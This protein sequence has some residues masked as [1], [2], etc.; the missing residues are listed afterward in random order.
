DRN[1]V[2]TFYREDIER[3]LEIR[4]QSVPRDSTKKAPMFVRLRTLRYLKM[5]PDAQGVTVGYQGVAARI[6]RVHQFGLRDE[7]G[8]GVMATYPVRELLGLS[9]ADEKRITET[10]INSLG[11]AG[12]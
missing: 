3:Y 8:P 12:K 7:A 1:D 6:A 9:A 11:S 5:Y 2:R 10:V 4:T